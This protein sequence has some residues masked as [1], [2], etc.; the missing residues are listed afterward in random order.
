M[1]WLLFSRSGISCKFWR[2][3]IRIQLFRTII[4]LYDLNRFFQIEMTDNSKLCNQRQVHAAVTCIE[5]G[6]I[7]LAHASGW[8]ISSENC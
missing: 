2:Q 3:N 7:S 5:G 1:I 8:R 4:S 6:V